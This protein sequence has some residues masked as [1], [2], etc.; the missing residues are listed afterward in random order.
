MKLLLTSQT[1]FLFFRLKTVFITLNV[2]DLHRAASF[3]PH[4]RGFYIFYAAA[5]SARAGSNVIRAIAN[6]VSLLIDA[7]AISDTGFIESSR[8]TFTFFV[9]SRKCFP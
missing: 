7:P 5:Y 6:M 3:I 8:G 9:A 1:G 2:A 4:F